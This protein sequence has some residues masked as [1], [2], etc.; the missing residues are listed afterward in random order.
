MPRYLGLL[1]FCVG[2][3]LCLVTTLWLRYSLM[4]GAQWVDVCQ[5][6]EGIWQCQ[7]R[8]GLGLMI[9]F[10]VLSWSALGSAL[11]AFILPGRLGRWLA[12]ISLLLALPAV[13]LYS[14]SLGVF[15][16]VLALLRLVRAPKPVVA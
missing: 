6:P 2:I 10:G 14:A 1:V 7:L 8:S 13:L 3:L 11:L 4:E 12:A 16:V 9:H 5:L 15:S